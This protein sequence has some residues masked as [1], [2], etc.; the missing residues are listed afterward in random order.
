MK[1]MFKKVLLFVMTLSM[2][3]TLCACAGGNNKETSQKAEGESSL[4][5]DQSSSQAASQETEEHKQG[6]ELVVGIPQ[7]LDSLDPHMAEAA[8]TRE[9]LFNVFE[10][11]VK[12]DSTGDYVP[13]VAS[14]FDVSDDGKV[15]T[16][17]LR[18]G[19][20]FHDGSDVT[21]DDVIYSINR[22]KDSSIRKDNYAVIDKVEK[23]DEKTVVI[24]LKEAN[25]EF[26]SFLSEAIIPASNKNPETN[27]IGTGPFKYVSRS[28]QENV[29]LERFDDY[30]GTKAYLDKVTLKIESD[31]NAIVMDLNGGSIDMFSRLTEDQYSQLDMK[32][33]SVSEGTMN[34]VQGLFLNNAEK[35]FDDVRVRQALC[36]AVDPQEVMDFMAGGKG[37]AIGSAMFPAFTKYYDQE[38]ANKYPKDVEKAKAL[39]TEAG[40]PDGFEMTIT[41]PSN[42][43]QHVDTAQ[44]VAEELKAIGV[45]A[46]INQVEW[47]TWLSDVYSA[48][49]YQSTVI[50]FDAANL[51][52]SALLARYQS[53]AD[54]NCF[55]FKSDEFDK[56]LDEAMKTVDDAKKTELYKKCAK[57]LSDEAASVYI[58]DLANL[59]ALRNTFDGYK[60]YPLYVLDLS[61][62][63][64]K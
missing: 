36:Y 48:R 26:I 4:A 8:G 13:A 31:V 33:I 46:K 18:D 15:Y 44:V 25:T 60:F 21:A 11:L 49:K 52:A 40:Y 6:G 32:N 35:P 1:T 42:Y 55:N 3:A 47:N 50:G 30:W 24:T 23:T 56:T 39:L 2:V 7:D 9:V 53:T 41:V 43:Q 28:A 22:V 51:T 62:I 58:Q 12:P 10:G 5:A 38:L 34:L 17:T 61:T 14:T 20:K 63:Y 54:N 64:Q 45:T 57:I 16:F 37:T 19:V 59:V 27:P 29:V